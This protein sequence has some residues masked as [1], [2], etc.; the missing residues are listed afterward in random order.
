MMN[1]T[2]NA[3]PYVVDDTQA[4]TPATVERDS[5]KIGLVGEFS[6][7][8]GP[9]KDRL[10]RKMP[11]GRKVRVVRMPGPLSPQEIDMLERVRVTRPNDIVE[12]ENGG[13]SLRKWTSD[14]ER[15]VTLLKIGGVE[16][17]P[18]G[19]RVRGRLTPS[20]VPDRPTQSNTGETLQGANA[21]QRM[22]TAGA[23]ADEV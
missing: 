3:N 13:L 8:V 5:A 6:R 19:G 17:Y 22:D 14:T 20:I 11:D 1:V 12:A 15:G 7:G 23:A 21:L 9:F 18:D 16:Y 10:Y 2:T 4:P